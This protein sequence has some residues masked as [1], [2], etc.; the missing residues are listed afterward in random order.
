MWKSTKIL[1]TGAGGFIGHHL[2]SYLKRKGNELQGI[3]LRRIHEVLD[4][5]QRYYWKKV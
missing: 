3:D 4:E 2:V 1:A 5:N